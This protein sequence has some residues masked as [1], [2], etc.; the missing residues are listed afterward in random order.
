[1]TEDRNAWNQQITEEFRAN[2]GA[3][4]GYFE[5]KTLLLLHH[6]GAKS[7]TAYI[8]PL[9]VF[10]QSDGTWAIV[11]SNGGRDQH[12]SWY[13]NLQA[14]PETTIELP[15]G[16]GAIATLQVKSRIAEG[17]ERDALFV[18]VKAAMPQFAEYEKGTERRIPLVVLEPV[19]G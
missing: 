2:G 6:T 8:S 7:G 11:A 19:E 18:N 16:S 14:H 4:G 12:P 13:F 17:T 9:A 5:G 3:V 10:T 15:D 1:M